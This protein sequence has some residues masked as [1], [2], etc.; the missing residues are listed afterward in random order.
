MTEK[1]IYVCDICG[2]EFADE[3]ECQVH[4]WKEKSPPYI[5][6]FEIIY[7][8][9]K[10]SL[11]LPIDS[12]INR[13]KAIYTKDKSAAQFLDDYFS[14]YYGS[15]G[16]SPY[17]G[18]PIRDNMIIYYDDDFCDCWLD[19]DEEYTKLDKIKNLFEK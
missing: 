16:E 5:G 15:A 1:T 6:R 10:K 14:S 4:E 7:Y 9:N 13:I 17:C 8:N 11:E 18:F 3:A 2:K 19:L 12:E